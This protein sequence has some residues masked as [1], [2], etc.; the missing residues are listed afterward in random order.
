MT[1]EVYPLKVLDLFSGIGGFSLGLGRVGMQTMA[2][3][4]IDPFCRK[5]LKKHWPDVPIFNDVRSLPD[6]FTGTVDVITGGYPCQ[7]FS[8]AGNRKAEE[9]PRH[10]WPAMLACIKTFKPTWVIAENVAGHITLGLD[11]VLTDLESEGYAWETF[12]IPAC[13]V[14]ASHRRDRVWIIA[15]TKHFRCH[16]ASEQGSDGKAVC[17]S[18]ERKESTREFK[19]MDT[20]PFMAYSNGAGFKEFNTPF[21]SE[22]KGLGGRRSNTKEL[23][24]PTSKGLPDWAGGEM[25]QPQPVTQ[26]E[27]PSGRE[28]ECNFRGVSYGV[29][30]RVDRLRALGNAVVPGIVT[31][32]GEYINAYRQGNQMDERY[33]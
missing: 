12:I 28:I 30:R 24:H 15:N 2:F 13:A 14:G 6:E 31:A 19:G 1:G 22:R 17:S 21:L 26:F 8:C 5:V 27:R 11:Q 16:S 20:P 29:S 9:D 25:E 10:L 32:I 33:L 3:C 7:P 4:E 18:A 23:C